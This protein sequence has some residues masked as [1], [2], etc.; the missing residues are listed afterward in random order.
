MSSTEYTPEESAPLRPLSDDERSLE[1]IHQKLDIAVLQT[2]TINGR[3][4][5]TDRKISEMGLRLDSLDR[6]MFE[7]IGLVKVMGGE[8]RQALAS[9]AEA[10]RISKSL[11]DAPARASWTDE[12]VQGIVKKHVSVEEKEADLE[13]R[14]REDAQLAR[15]KMR[16][17]LVRLCYILGTVL[18]AALAHYLR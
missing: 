17:N 10:N 9:A 2:R 14:A 4:A 16:T 13:L 5:G 11:R 3:I 18:L 1:G 6:G 7:L 8:I 15:A 12:I